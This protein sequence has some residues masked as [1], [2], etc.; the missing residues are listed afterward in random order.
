MARSGKAFHDIGFELGNMARPVA[1]DRREI[2]RSPKCKGPRARAWAVL[3]TG[4]GWGAGCE[5]E[6]G[7]G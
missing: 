1:M 7:Q 5:Q 6:E 2:P 3:G 4:R